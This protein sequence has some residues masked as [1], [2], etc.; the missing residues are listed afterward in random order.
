[1]PSRPYLPN[2][3][4]QPV[5]FEQV[6]PIQG[7]KVG[8]A[9]PKRWDASPSSG[10]CWYARESWVLSTRLEQLGRDGITIDNK[11]ISIIMK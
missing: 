3:I 2:K 7:C 5:P 4:L 1:M 11:I 10:R 6:L 9:D 8:S